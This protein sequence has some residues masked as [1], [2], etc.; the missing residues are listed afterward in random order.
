[1]VGCVRA[2]NGD[3]DDATNSFE[4]IELIGQSCGGRRYNN[5][6]DNNHCRVA[7]TNFNGARETGKPE[8]RPDGTGGLTHGNEFSTYLVVNDVPLEIYIVNGSNMV[9]VQ[10]MSKTKCIR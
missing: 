3:A 1:M 5:R 7:Q 4:G 6:H 2:R 10:G 8:E 9:G